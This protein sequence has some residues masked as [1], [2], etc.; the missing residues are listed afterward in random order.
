MSRR[1]GRENRTKPVAHAAGIVDDALG[2]AVLL[3]KEIQTLPQAVVPT[4][5]IAWSGATQ[6][7]G[8]RMIK[9]KRD[10]SK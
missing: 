10:S 5:R 2:R 4:Q 8:K 3:P 6:S 1:R 9:S 7:K